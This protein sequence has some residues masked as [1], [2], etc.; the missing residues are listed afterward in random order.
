MRKTKILPLVAP[1]LSNFPT[2]RHGFFDRHGGISVLPYE[3]NNVSFGVGDQE[4][5]VRQNRERIK[6]SLGIPYLLSAHQV[7]GE[8]VYST[9]GRIVDKD[10]EVE[11]CDALITSQDGVGLMIQQADC[12]AVLLYDPVKRVIG[13]IHCG[14]RGSVLGIVGKTIEEMTRDFKCQPKDIVAAVSPSLGPCCAEFINYRKELPESF[15]DF[16]VKEFYF[17]FWKI[18]RKQLVDAGVK[19]EAIV[20][21]EICTSCSREYFSYR[22]SQR[23]GLQATGRNCSI[24]VIA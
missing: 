1:H 2:I 18:T 17:D 20:A 10:E 8:R 13:A 7:H 4:S 3:S 23:E 21:M 12:Q 5:S 15:C 16:Q 9:A 6:E 19:S 14:W 11:G 22:R 24:I